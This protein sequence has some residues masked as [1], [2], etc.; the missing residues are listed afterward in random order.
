M[1]GLCIISRRRCTVRMEMVLMFFSLCSWMSNI[2]ADFTI[3][4]EY[5]EIFS[6]IINWCM[7][8][9]YPILNLLWF[10]IDSHHCMYETNLWHSARPSPTILCNIIYLKV[11]RALWAERLLTDVKCKTYA[12]HW[13]D[14]SLKGDGSIRCESFYPIR[15]S[16]TVSRQLLFKDI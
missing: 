12:M 9:K 10:R 14:D 16:F 6:F 2:G 4:N 11:Y 1:I 3:S 8:A 5:Q 15:G 13:S 7:L